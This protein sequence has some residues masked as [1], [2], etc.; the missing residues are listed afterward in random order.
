[1]H[2]R[3][4]IDP[5]QLIMVAVCVMISAAV[6][7]SILNAG[8]DLAGSKFLAAA[9]VIVYLALLLTHSRWARPGGRQFHA[10]AFFAA[11]FLAT[12]WIMAALVQLRVLGAGV[13]VFMPLVALAAGYFQLRGQLI[14]IAVA[15]LQ[16]L[17]AAWLL[18]NGPGL[19][20]EASAGFGAATVF[21]SLFVHLARREAAARA[22]AEKLSA[23]LWEK[24]DQAEALA[25]EQERVRVAREIHDGLGHELMNAMVQLEVAHNLVATNPGAAS[26]AIEL[27]RSS[28]KDGLA[29]LRTAVSRLRES[30]LDEMPLSEGIARLAADLDG[31]GVTVRYE[32]HGIPR[33]LGQDVTLCLYRGV[34]EGLNNIRK[35]AGARHAAVILDYSETGHVRVTISD[36]GAGPAS[37]TSPGFGLIGLAERARL[38]GGTLTAGGTGQ[39]G[40]QLRM[41]LPG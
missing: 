13:L 7:V 33:I 29:D 6:G 3:R 36:D 27:A 4:H 40:F 25:T 14:V 31:S 11:M 23:R 5:E 38:A 16:F 8:P 37:T 18:D 26:R 1:M 2:L 28:V 39:H 21:V 34:Q 41:E 22:E 30:P 12:A 17:G 9:G 35:H 24:L 10:V 19:L 32:C 20:L 15:G